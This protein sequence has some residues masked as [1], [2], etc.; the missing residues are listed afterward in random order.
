[1]RVE[2]LLKICPSNNGRKTTIK[3]VR[4]AKRDGEVGASIRALHP[5]DPYQ[6][7]LC[8]IALNHMDRL[9]KVLLIL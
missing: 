3:V 7:I 8:L 2:V 4:G 1:M 9:T 5:Y 6:M